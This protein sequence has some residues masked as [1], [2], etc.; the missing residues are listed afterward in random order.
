EFGARGNN[1]LRLPTTQHS[2]GGLYSV[3]SGYVFGN[4]DDAG[5][6]M[7]LAPYG[8]RA[9]YD[10]PLFRYSGD[11]VFVNEDALKH[12][13]Q[14]SK[15]YDDF[16]TRFK[17]FADIAAWAQREV[18]EAIL[19]TFKTRLKHNYHP[20]LCYAGGVALNAVANARLLKEGIV[21]NLYIQ[22]AAADNG[23]SIGCAY[24]GWLEV[25][26]KEKQQHI[27]STYFGKS[28][29]EEE[30]QNAINKYTAIF[31]VSGIN[32]IH[33]DNVA[34][35]TAQY[36][37]KGKI[38]AWYQNGAEFGPRALGNRSILADP[39]LPEVQA[40]IN[41]EIKFRE[42]F[43]PFAPSVLAED[44]TK[45]FRYAYESPYMILV[46]EVLPEYRELLPGVTHA[47]NSARVQTVTRS[48]NPEYYALL[49]AFKAESGIGILLNTSF[50]KRRQPIVE[51]PE[52][53]IELFLETALDIL[54]IGNLV[55]QKKDV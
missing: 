10:T 14:P 17:Y 32:I 15:G 44:V 46:D 24:Y 35:Q 13:T 25:L 30:A 36:L 9:L 1:E 19:Y 16:K 51:T 38:V 2:I 11:R 41:R 4:M 50:N 22:P 31:K 40:F 3:I 8:N 12:L 53:A 42:D 55:L 49:Q 37:A 34:A 28:Y 48:M 20:N 54:V 29:P 23:L 5:K 26:K 39:G 27:G 18:E 45:Y 43:R 33:P 21:E 47:D 6:L 52:Q 7:G